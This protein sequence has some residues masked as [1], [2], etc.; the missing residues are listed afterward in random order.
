MA[1]LAWT[2]V[3]SQFLAVFGQPTCGD[4]KSEYKR[5]GCCGQ[6]TKQF[7]TDGLEP[8]LC[9][10]GCAPYGFDKWPQ[11]PALVKAMGEQCD[12]MVH[13]GDL[14]GGSTGLHCNRSYMEQPIAQMMTAGKPLLFIPGDNEVADCHRAASANPPDPVDFLKAED[15]RNFFIERFFQDTT[16]DLTG[17]MQLSTQ[18]ADCPFN[19]Y[20]ENFGVAISTYEIPGGQF[21][22]ADESSRQPMQNTVDPIADRKAMFDRAWGCGETWLE[23]SFEKAHAAG[24]TTL[25]LFYH[26]GFWQNDG[27]FPKSYGNTLSSYGFGGDIWNETTLGYYTPYVPVA[28]KILGLAQQYPDLMVYNVVSDWHF[29]HMQNPQRQKNLMVVM[30]EGDESGLETFVKFK[31]TRD[32]GIMV[33]EVYVDT[34]SAL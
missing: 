25:F 5:Q 15:A 13:V 10:V 23:Q 14:M 17:T 32:R 7:D 24:L 2:A 18:S 1:C 33:Q 30:T 8:T 31:L 27:S 3:L 22:L 29:F 6:P 9:A 19:T 16:T 4:V 11:W 20:V 26:A 28:D 12:L 21:Y 34:A